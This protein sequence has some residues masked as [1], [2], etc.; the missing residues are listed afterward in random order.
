MPETIEVEIREGSKT[1]AILAR[2]QITIAGVKAGADGA[3]G[4]PGADGMTV[5]LTNEAHTLPT[6]TDGTVDY[7]GSGTGVSVYEGLNKLTS[8]G[9]GT[10][11]GKYKVTAVG[12]SIT[13]G[14]SANFGGD[15]LFTDHSKMTDNTAK[16]TYTI[17]GRTLLN[18]KSFTFIKE[19]TFAKSL[20]GDTG[21]T[22]PRG[23]QGPEPD[24]SQFLTTTTTI[25]GGKIT[26]GRLVS[27]DFAMPVS[28]Q[29]LASGTGAGLTEEEMTATD[30]TSSS[31][32]WDTYSFA[33]MGI[34]LDAG[35]INAKNFYIDPDG[36]A[37][38]RGDMDIEG[39][40]TIAG[41]L[42]ST[43]FDFELDPSD[44]PILDENGYRQLRFKPEVKFGDQRFDDFRTDFRTIA[45]SYAGRYDDVTYDN[46]NG[47]TISEAPSD[48]DSGFTPTFTASHTYIKR[49]DTQIEVGD[50][51][52][53][54]EN[55]E[56][57]KASSAQD[58]AIVG[59]LWQGLD[60][61]IKDSPLD[62]FLPNGKDTSEKPHH[63]RDSLGNKI[64]VTDRDIK[65]IWRVASIG[66]SR[67]GRLTGM[68]VCDQNGLV[69]VG[70]L[71][72]SSDTPGYVMKQ[73]TEW[74]II[75]FED[76]TPQYEERQTI[77]SYTVGKCMEDCAF[78]AEGKA[79][80][81]YGYL[82]CG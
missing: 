18:G 39:G 17:T 51:V 31:T 71:V 34:N 48:K 57:V 77:T 78:D 59:I 66:D 33:G 41:G 15:R 45:E 73:P 11:V 30:V 70:D 76:G 1:S 21:P 23:F 42:A 67:E 16:I 43:I 69:L 25:S 58:T 61:T 35:A 2:D 8:D 55:N 79:E 44:A 10:G 81:V 50:L 22:G 54:D 40:A 36:N 4:T 47:A 72:C 6:Q 5:I 80:G 24:V 20:Q 62:K 37:K 53:L 14:G 74:V 3:P 12:T 56:L 64:P 60:F 7:F 38:F 68:K 32:L 19:Q 65:T 29:S 27:G 28:A 9:V 13:V 82:Y 52:K 26:T 49:N 75:G 63:Y 46:D